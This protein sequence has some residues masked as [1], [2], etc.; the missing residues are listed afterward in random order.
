MININVNFFFQFIYLFT[1]LVM[2]MSKGNVFML[3]TLLNEI[4]SFIP[5]LILVMKTCYS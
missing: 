3:Y 1:F 5:F 4:I 2:I